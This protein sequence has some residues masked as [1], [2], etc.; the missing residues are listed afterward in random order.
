[1]KKNIDVEQF[2]YKYLV[3]NLTLPEC[4]RFFNCGKTTLVRIC[5]KHNIKKDKS[6]V[7]KN[8]SKKATV[9]KYDSMILDLY[10]K[11][12]T[13]SEIRKTL[14]ISDKIL[15]RCLNSNGI[16]SYNKKPKRVK[17]KKI[18]GLNLVQDRDWL[19]H[20][21]IEL[22]KTVEQICLEF[23]VSNKKVR[24]FKA[25][26]GIEKSKEQRN[27]FITHVKSSLVKDRE[28]LY[29]EYIT[30]NRKIKD[31]A[32]SE[33]VSSWMVL[34]YINKFEL[35]KSKTDKLKNITSSKLDKGLI[36]SIEGKTTH[37][38][39]DMFGWSHSAI[40]SL[41]KKLGCTT[42]QQIQEEIQGRKIQNNLEKSFQ[43]QTGLQFYNK[44][45]PNLKRKPDFIVKD[46]VY[47]NLDGLYWH[48]QDVIEDSFH[49]YNMRLQFEEKGYRLIQFRE[50][51]IKYKMQIVQSMINNLKGQTK[52]IYARKCQI[53]DISQKKAS[54][55]LDSSHLMGKTFAKFKGLIFENEIVC[56]LGYKKI[57]TGLKI[58][59]FCNALNTQVIGG[60]SKLL[61]SVLNNESFEY[62]DYWV[63]LRYGTGDYLRPL[64]FQHIKDTLGWKWTDR[65]KTYNRLK[66]R[67]NMDNRGYTE[68]QHAKELGLSRI[69]DAGQ[70]LYRKNLI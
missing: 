20:Q 9:S 55:F 16:F 17:V 47:C 50:D 13:N 68:K 58:E 37:E 52:K 7:G 5:S 14:S 21:Y 6:L 46:N 48:S 66:C 29:N 15:I 25:K 10:K 44:F 39:A 33:S 62:V 38:I 8:I 30:K 35:K 18:R 45:L 22:N 23:K 27:S 65:D 36:I 64:G 69:Y 2:K 54:D 12:A 31:I 42:I 59:R 70:R 60:F 24:E 61:N 63:D 56:L 11:G 51:E 43:E 26:F 34:Q 57:G 4:A 41:I 3:E 40:C 67:A 19:Y 28:W 32:K 53:V 1:M 49:H